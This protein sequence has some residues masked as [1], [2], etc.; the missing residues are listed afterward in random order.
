[1]RFFVKFD[2]VTI[3]FFEVEIDASDEQEAKQIIQ[4]NLLNMKKIAA[5]KTGFELQAQDFEITEMAKPS[6]YCGPFYEFE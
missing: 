3:D 6:T 5:E 2:R 1:M 4:E